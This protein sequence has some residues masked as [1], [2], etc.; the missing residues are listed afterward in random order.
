MAL[1]C[2]DPSADDVGRDTRLFAEA[3]ADLVG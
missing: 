1:I 3:V 2:P